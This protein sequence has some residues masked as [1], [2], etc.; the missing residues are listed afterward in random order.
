MKK[1]KLKMMKKMMNSQE[2]M[3]NKN[4]IFRKTWKWKKKNKIN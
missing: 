3:S 2:V 1:K 4:Q